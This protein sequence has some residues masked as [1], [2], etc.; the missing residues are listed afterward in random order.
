MNDLCGTSFYADV[1]I[2]I[3]NNNKEEEEEEEEE[4]IYKHFRRLKALYNL[5]ISAEPNSR[6]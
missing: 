4:G 5:K 6:N 2:I 1:V 3:I